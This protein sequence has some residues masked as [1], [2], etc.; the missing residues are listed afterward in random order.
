M[1]KCNKLVEEGKAYDWK[2][3][4]ASYSYA[5]DCCLD[6][7]AVSQS[8]SPGF[9]ARRINGQTPLESLCLTAAICTTPHYPHRFRGGRRMRVADGAR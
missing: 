1:A 9:W 5:Q 4:K 7:L 6:L 2:R 8:L 3:A